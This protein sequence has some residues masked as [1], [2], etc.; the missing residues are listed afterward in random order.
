MS[1]VTAMR[2][3]AHEIDFVYCGHHETPTP[4]RLGGILVS[5]QE[6]GEQPGHSDDSSTSRFLRRNE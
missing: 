5:P 3:I 1:G 6:T 2:T 4:L